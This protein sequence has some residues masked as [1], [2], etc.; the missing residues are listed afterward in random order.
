MFSFW[1]LSGSRVR[2]RKEGR[3]KEQGKKERE[4]DK[5]WK[6]RRRDSEKG[7]EEQINKQTKPN[8]TNKNRVEREQSRI[9]RKS[10]YEK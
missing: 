1:E 4:R 3:N 9:G 6:W 2:R 5:D 8:T 7:G 10:G